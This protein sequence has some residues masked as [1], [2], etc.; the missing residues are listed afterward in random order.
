MQ[1]VT[2]GVERRLQLD[3]RL[4]IVLLVV[5]AADGVVQLVELVEDDLLFCA[6]RGVDGIVEEVENPG[7]LGVSRSSM[8]VCL[9]W[10][11]I[12]RLMMRHA[13]ELSA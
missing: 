9:L 7:V 4:V 1:S 6:R 8:M 2:Y 13:T 5:V 3:R 10:V 12:L 11:A